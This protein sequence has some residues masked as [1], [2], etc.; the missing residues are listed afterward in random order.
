MIWEL[1]QIKDIVALLTEG[2]AAW[3]SLWTIFYTVSAAVVAL[4]ASG[5]IQTPYRWPASTLA[6]VGFLFCCSL[7]ATTGRSTRCACSGKP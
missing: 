1:S 7:Q 5:K 4:I 3:Q 6:L 2:S